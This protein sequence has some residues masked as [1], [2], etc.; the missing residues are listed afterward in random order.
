M[1]QWTA[2][3]REERYEDAWAI[4]AAVLARRNPAQRDDPAMPFHKRWLWDG[5]SF[6]GEQVLVR[7]YH[8]LGDIIQFARYLPLLSRRVAQLTVEAP[9]A[10]LG[11]LALIAPEGTALVPFDPASPLPR[12]ACDIEITELDFALRQPPTAAPPPYLRVAPAIL[13]EGTIAYC[14]GS[15][16]WDPERSIPAHLLAPLCSLAPS[17]T[18]MPE[19]TRLNMLN[20][21]G[22]PLD[23]MATAALV[24]G[25]DLVITV[26]T[27]IAHLSGALGR[28]TWLMLKAAPD[29][30]WSPTRRT[31]PWYPA[32]RLYVQPSPGDWRAV[33]ARIERDLMVRHLR[34]APPSPANEEIM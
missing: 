9:P 32:T 17:L 20:P 1:Q 25:A 23:M 31:T 14:H 6:D 10:L 13:P 22:C 11:I 26:D 2:A 24:A 4:C 29:W 18:L 16:E 34:Q 3:M 15:G 8:G 33:I 28:P 5:R 27:M 30:R 12:S 19:P 21:E 7:C